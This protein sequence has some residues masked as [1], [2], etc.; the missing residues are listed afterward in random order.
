[1][2]LLSCCCCATPTERLDTGEGGNEVTSTGRSAKGPQQSLREIMLLEA[3]WLDA[4]RE[5]ARDLLFSE[6]WGWRCKTTAQDFAEVLEKVASQPRL[7]DDLIQNCS[8][9]DGWGRFYWRD[10]LYKY[11]IS[12]QAQEFAAQLSDEALGMSDAVAQEWLDRLDSYTLA[13]CESECEDDLAIA[14]ETEMYSKSYV[15]RPPWAR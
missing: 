14:C 12:V 2:A 8:E 13:N 6:E 3:Q 10:E 11:Q 9:P 7:L 1:M 5:D 4:E 15:T